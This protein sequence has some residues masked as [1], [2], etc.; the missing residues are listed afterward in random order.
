MTEATIARTRG[1]RQRGAEEM[2]VLTARPVAYNFVYL[3][4][5]VGSRARRDRPVLGASGLVHVRARVPRR[6]VAPAGAAQLRAR[7]RSTASSSRAGAANDLVGVFLCAAPVGSPF[8]AAQARHLAHHR[9]LGTADDPDRDLH[10]GEDKRTRSG[11][12]PHFLER[13]ARRLRRDGADGPAG[14]AG[15][16]RG[17]IGARATCSRSSSCRRRSPAGSRCAFAWWVYPALW[18]APL[19]TVTVLCHLV[20]SF[21][22]HAITD[23]EAAPTATG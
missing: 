4:A 10:S 6:V 1:A 11:P 17:G 18:L 23:S 14:A 21:V 20:R 9:L 3:G 13:P 22:E 19:A 7:G 12:R 15:A 8:G 2:T 5:R 16:P